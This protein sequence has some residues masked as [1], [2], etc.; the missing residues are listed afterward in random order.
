MSLHVPSFI[1]LFAV[2]NV[3][4]YYMLNSPKHCNCNCVVEPTQAIPPP[5]CALPEVHS[6]MRKGGWSLLAVYVGTAR[7]AALNARWTS[8]VGQD[9]TIFKLFDGKRDGYFVD[10][11]ANDA[12]YLSNTL[13]LEQEYGWRGLCIEANPA[14]I[15]MLSRRNC[16]VVQAVVGEMDNLE[17]QFLFNGG[18]GGIVGSEFDNKEGGSHVLKTVSLQNMF[19]YL[20]VPRAID[21]M[22]LDIEGAEEWAFQKFPWSK[23]TFSVI[24]AE[25][26]KPNLKEALMLRGYTYVCDHGDFGDELWIHSSFGTLAET[27]SK[28]GIHPS[29]LGDSK[30]QCT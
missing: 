26:P 20:A 2:I 28:L 11:A 21:Y 16:Q 29:R 6:D 14:Y 13:T 9:R 8:Q 5:A 1:F 15:D 7:E 24:T 30:R 12:V 22:S 3:V 17:V 23:Y 10:L 25:R 18:L 27:M 4:F 19:H